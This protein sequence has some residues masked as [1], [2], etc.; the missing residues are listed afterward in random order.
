LFED[1]LKL[2]V[3]IILGKWLRPSDGLLLETKLGFEV[4]DKDDD[5]L[6]EDG[7]DCLDED[8]DEEDCLDEDDDEEEDDEE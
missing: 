7:E 6:D 5:F 2:S 4:L 1:G 3:G 8:D